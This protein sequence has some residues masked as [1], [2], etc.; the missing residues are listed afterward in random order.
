MFL[1]SGSQR[2]LWGLGFPCA[3]CDPV[4]KVGQALFEEFK[5]H[6]FQQWAVDAADNQMQIILSC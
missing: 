6:L 3:G 2:F 1:C 4:S 5:S